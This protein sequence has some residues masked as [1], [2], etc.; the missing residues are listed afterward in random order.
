[1]WLWRIW[2]NLE[3]SVIVESFRSLSAEEWVEDYEGH[4]VKDEV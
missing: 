1:M 4:T 3:E 2:S